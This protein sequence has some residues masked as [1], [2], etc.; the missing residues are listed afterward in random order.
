MVWLIRDLIE[1][2][3]EVLREI[4]KYYKSDEYK[5]KKRKLAAKKYAENL[6][7]TDYKRYQ[8]EMLKAK[9]IQS[10]NEKLSFEI[11][12]K[13]KENFLQKTEV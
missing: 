6:K 2:G 12:K 4:I 1:L 11:A 5:E 9:I 10:R 3:Y 13:P 7:K 8:K